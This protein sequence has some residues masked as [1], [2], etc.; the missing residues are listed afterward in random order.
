MK[1]IAVYAGSF[2]P[3]TYGHQDILYKAIETFDVVYAAVGNNPRKKHLFTLEERMNMIK[4]ADTGAKVV[5]FDGSLARFCIKNDCTHIVRGLR[6]VTDY[7]YEIQLAA[8]N[9]EYAYNV[10]T[11]FFIPDAEHLHI[12]SSMVKEL[13]SLDENVEKFVGSH[14]SSMLRSKIR[15][16]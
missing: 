11:V 16:D 7:E 14:V 12:S 6:S 15:K 5:S 10:D 1:R 9:K 8:I 2:D 4:Y 3:V 13:V